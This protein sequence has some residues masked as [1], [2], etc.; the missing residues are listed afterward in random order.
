MGDGW[1]KQAYYYTLTTPAQWVSFATAPADADLSTFH[2]DYGK[3]YAL[4]SGFELPIDSAAGTGAMVR[5][6]KGSGAMQC[7]ITTE[8]FQNGINPGFNIMCFYKKSTYL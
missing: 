1:Y 7:Y 5:L 6:H 3:S 8:A 2:I 4:I